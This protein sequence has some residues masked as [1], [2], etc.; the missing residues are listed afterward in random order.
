MA[1]SE[2]LR[3]HARWQEENRRLHPDSVDALA[4]AGVFRLRVPKH[5]GG[6]EATT[7]TL[8]DVAAE[9]GRAD[10]SVGWTASVYWI[11]TWMVGLFPDEAQEEVFDTP[12]V[13]VCGT[14]SPSATARPEPGGAV[15]N[16]RWSFISGAWHSHWQVVLVMAP[17]GGGES[18]PIMGLVPMDELSAV[19][20]WHTSGLRGSG[21]ITTVADEVFIPSHRI[22]AV[23]DV[24]RQRYSSDRN[25]DLLMFRA[26]MPAVANASSVGAPVGLARA[27]MENFR[28][29]MPN[30]AITYT[31]YTSQSEAPAIH[32]RIAESMSKMDQAEFHA[33]RLVDSLD[34]KAAVNESWS[35][36][37][38]ARARM[39][40]GAVGALAAEGTSILNGVSG[41]SSIYLDVPIQRTA[42]DL[43][44]LN[45]HP[46]IN[47]VMGN[48][49]YGRV[50]CGL[51]PN[52]SY[53]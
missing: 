2:V 40:V 27:A 22:V 20:D 37:E 9:L 31:D 18:Q 49:L 50:L 25:R 13:R 53:I 1:I 30:R 5:H 28:E 48:E 33:K 16:G 14:L 41:G 35:V 39:D 23:A 24:L 47:A 17:A 10:G 19:D 7:R 45:Q 38:R 26:P 4:D 21:S 51:E 11:P 36:E 43:H 29:R 52:T 46:L 6:Y 15:V 8:L 12:D 42:R 32:H 34:Q 44:A 3:G